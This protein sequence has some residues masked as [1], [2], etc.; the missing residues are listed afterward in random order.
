MTNLCISSLI[1]SHSLTFATHRRWHQTNDWFTGERKT[2]SYRV[3]TAWHSFLSFTFE[4]YWDFL[5]ILTGDGLMTAMWPSASACTTPSSEQTKVQHTIIRSLVLGD[6]IHS[7][8][9]FLLTIFLPTCGPNK[10][11]HYFCDVYPLLKLACMD[12]YRIGLLVLLIQV[13][14]LWWLLWFWWL[15]ILILHKIKDYPA[16]SC[17]K[18]LSTCSSHVTLVVLFMPV[19]FI[20]IRSAETFPEDKVFALFYTII[21]PMFNP[22]DLPHWR[23]LEMKNA[24]KK[25]VSSIS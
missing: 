10:I 14:L 12:T 17:T 4:P 16:E 20:Y 24:V 7:A 9:Q 19:L 8:S 13:W 3:V 23:N 11:D 1:T 22:S 18:A 5:C 2:N 6:P 21:A 25:V 15:L